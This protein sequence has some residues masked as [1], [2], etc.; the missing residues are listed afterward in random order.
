MRRPLDL[1]FTLALVGCLLAGCSSDLCSQE[2]ALAENLSNQFDACA[3]SG[4]SFT[5]D[6]GESAFETSCQ[7]ALKS[8]TPSDQANLSREVDCYS[9]L[10]VLQCKWLTEGTAAASDKTGKV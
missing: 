1:T 6:A 3:D 7:T 10:P 9:G 5:L 2:Y 8:C 4:I